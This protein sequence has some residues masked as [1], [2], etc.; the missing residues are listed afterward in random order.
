[1]REPPSIECT[2]RLKRLEVRPRLTTIP[3]AMPKPT[4]PTCNVLL[5][6]P[7]PSI[8][9]RGIDHTAIGC[10]IR[11]TSTYLRH[12]QCLPTKNPLALSRLLPPNRESLKELSTPHRALSAEKGEVGVISLVLYKYTD[13][14]AL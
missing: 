8:S 2:K 10:P 3:S 4:S 1:M 7:N 14:V 12:S 11:G 9:S 13:N 5:T 6:H